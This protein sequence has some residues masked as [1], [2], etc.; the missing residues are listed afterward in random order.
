MKFVRAFIF[1]FIMCFG[2]S[3]ANAQGAQV[4]F[5]G[6][7]HDSSLPIEMAADELTIN[8]EDG[9]AVFKGNVVIGQGQMRLSATLVQVE[10]AAAQGDVSG[11]ISRLIAS[12][13]VTLVSGAEAAEAETAIYSVE[14]GV[15]IMTGNVLLTQGAN[16][17]SS[18][19]LEVDLKTG[20]GTMKGRVRTILQ[21]GGN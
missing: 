6:L 16:A 21:S 2:A 8:Q 9:T 18:E 12:G 11:K 13:G 5:G 17:L 10:Y 14:T 7:Q 15:I 1:S 20:T 19:S 3:S 4:A